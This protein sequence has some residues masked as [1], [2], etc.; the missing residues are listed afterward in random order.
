VAEGLSDEVSVRW[1]SSGVIHINGHIEEDV[2]F[3]SGYVTARERLWQMELTRRLAK[4]RM[5]EI[6][7]SRAL[8]AD[9]LF[10]TLGIDSL[11]RTIYNEISPESK[12]WLEKYAEGIN[13]FL[14]NADD[15]IPV[16]FV[17]M[18]FTPE[19]W[20]PQDCLLQNR[21]LAWFLNFNWK[22]DLLYWHLQQVLPPGRFQD[23][24]PVWANDP[25]IISVKN[26]GEIIQHLT[27]VLATV[28][29]ITGMRAT[30]TGSN[31]WVVSPQL[32]TNGSA[33]LA[34]DPHLGIQF[35][36]IWIELHLTAPNL[37]VSGFSLPGLP[38]IVIGRNDNIAWGL[39]NG[40]VDD[41]DYFVE[42]VDTLAGVYLKNDKKF[43]LKI[44][45]RSVKIKDQP[46]LPLKIY[47][48]ENG[49]I[50][51]AVF[52]QI[53]P[54]KVL[55]LRWT[56]YTSS[57]EIATFI[58]LAKARD[59]TDFENSLRTFGVPAQNF[60]YADRAGNIGYR[61]GGLIPVRTYETGLIPQQTRDS[62][63]FWN[64]WV[65]FSKMP[66]IKNPRIGFIVSANNQM[67]E[68]YPYYV[69]EI[70]E[71]PFR[72]MR[73]D[74]QIIESGKLDRRDMQRMQSDNIDLMAQEILP[75]MMS[76]FS[77]DE[78]QPELIDKIKQLLQNWDYRMEKTSI[79]AAVYEVWKYYLIKN[80]F[81]DEMQQ[82][83]FTLFTDIPNFYLRIFHQ[84]IINENSKWFDD[85]GSQSIETR[86]DIVRKS[87][88]ETLQYLNE[89]K[90]S[91][92]EDWQWGKIHRLNLEHVLGRIPLTKSILNEGPFPVGGNGVT[93]N[94]ATYAFDN[95][96]DMLSGPS[97]RFI[98]DWSEPEVYYGI[99]PGGNSGNF[100]SSFYNNQMDF[101]L[102]GSLK[103]TK[104]TSHPGALEIRLVP[105]LK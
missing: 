53:Q 8:A 24:W 74:Q 66:S 76:E 88:R 37:N 42:V 50:F 102:R 30:H 34:N 49:P 12:L 97:H 63:F 41:S 96:F 89:V 32:A 16:E 4:G 35:P 84:V 21:I 27:T 65:P 104:M 93:V 2:I 73:I 79:A 103:R 26:T 87:F 54:S 46:D 90:G 55:T 61:L 69:S 14:K 99:L 25:P 18:N 1:D 23:I 19:K 38:G 20:T 68:N 71:P 13:A 5:S 83:A 10:L 45:H 28:Y 39:T 92:L 36:S 40:M 100:I 51:N 75:I 58:S 77:V 91:Q 31:S 15:D 6:F 56:G 59:W 62:R 81:I 70:W 17:L 47:Y 72:S 29:N 57:D 3:A 98:V 43:P 82:P 60:M 80:I 105:G 33:M 9:K 7:G 94:A 11:T 48:S 64:G 52:P 95:P 67:I 85:V 78:N 22:A 44:Y 86:S 101:W